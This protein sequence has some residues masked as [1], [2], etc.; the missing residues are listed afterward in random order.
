MLIAGAGGHA[1]ELL[2]E[3]QQLSDEPLCFF[4][5]TPGAKDSLYNSFKILHTLDEVRALFNK[6]NRFIIGVGK[7]TLRSSLC[8]KLETIG[9]R[10]SSLISK[11]SVIGSNGIQLE[12][13]LNVMSG[14]ILTT[15]IHI[16]KGT[17]I[18]IHS[19]I[20]HNCRVGEFCELSP[21]CRLL[22][23]VQVGDFV[24]IGT[25]AILLPGIKVGSH[26][27]IGAGSVVTKNVVTGQKVIGNPAKPLTPKQ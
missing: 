11:S 25:G 22:G 26:V 27:I 20:H 6:D 1:R 5:D 18:H 3:W 9:G 14:A 17:L 21:G 13:G 4:D 12:E 10:L 16:G 2:F 24:S 23:G 15:D 7:P 8:D 19:S